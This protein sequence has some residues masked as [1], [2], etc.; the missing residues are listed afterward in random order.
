MDVPYWPSPALRAVSAHRLRGGKVS[1]S[2]RGPSGHSSLPWGRLP[3]RI[4]G[5]G[6]SRV[7]GEV[8]WVPSVGL[9]DS[10]RAFPTVAATLPERH[11]PRRE[12]NEFQVLDGERDEAV[13]AADVGV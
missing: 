11:R 13:A 1:R 5:L 4:P 2:G 12:L 6:T 9:H 10:V 3:S 8:S 7:L